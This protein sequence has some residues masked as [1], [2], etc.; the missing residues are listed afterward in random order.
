[1][2]EVESS[3]P[4]PRRGLARW[5]RSPAVAYFLLAILFLY[6]V[7]LTGRSYLLR[8]I[9]TFFH[10]WQVAVR[11][12]VQT[13]HLPLWNHDTF[14][15]IPLLANLQSGVFYPVNWLHWVLPFDFSLTLGM[16]IHLTLAGVLMYRFLGRVGVSGWNG[17]LGGALF[18]LS[19]WS[20]AYLEFPMKLGSAVWIP[21]L[22]TGL[23]DAMGSGRRRG[24]ATAALAVALSILAG[25]PQLAMFGLISAG[26]LWLFLVGPVWRSTDL[27]MGQKLH[28]I[29]ALPVAGIVAGLVAA[30][31]LVP[32]A[33]MSA[34]S[35]KAQPYEATVAM[36]RSLD[37]KGLAGLVDP[38]FLGFPGVDRYWGGEV[39]EYCFGAF[40]VGGVGFVL[41]LLAL[42]TLGR[43]SR[44]RRRP[45]EE[46][47]D[48]PVVPAVIPRF[49]FT[50]LVV[51]ILLALGKN[52]PLYPL[53]HE[54][55]PGFGRSRW[56][57][58]AGLLIAAALAPLAGIGLAYVRAE[59][60]RLRLASLA[61]VTFGA[62]MLVAA[63]VAGGPLA[64]AW[65]SAQLAGSPA[66][67]IAAYDAWHD[68]WH[69]S[70]W[71]R[72]GLLVAAGALGLL[73]RQIRSRV[74]IA[75]IAVVLLD[76]FLVGR[77]FEYPTGRDFYDTVPAANRAL[78][79]ELD[80]QRI[81][82][83][84]ATDQLGNF[85]YGNRNPTAFA[86][87]RRAMLCNANVPAGIAQANGCEPLNP[88]RHEAFS[89]VFDSER[90]PHEIRERIFDL[91][92]AARLVE[93]R[94]VRPLEIPNLEDPEAGLSFN[95]HRPRLGRA[96]VLTGWRTMAD[97]P[98]A[99]DALT[100]A[101]HSP[102]HVTLVEIPEDAPP[103]A[104][105]DRP[106]RGVS[107]PVEWSN[108]PNSIRAAWAAGDGG[109]LRIL[110]S[111]A[112]GWEAT[113]N[114][115]PAP[116]LRSDFLFL[117]VPVPP[118]SVEVELNYRP[119]SLRTGAI[120]SAVGLLL[121][122]LLC[123]PSRRVEPADS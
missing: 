95:P 17:F 109:I 82:T 51:G 111:W 101:N 20:L 72:A 63:L 31:Q 70:L 78:A 67:Q 8:D 103:L 99:L 97:G 58:T 69:A 60:E 16:V 107:T 30:I 84:R 40:Y 44:R 90:T 65:R 42:P 3:A 32:A 117:A 73:L 7:T 35:S 121:L 53:L 29:G 27:P 39:V 119:A 89:Q 76:L 18:A 1:M 55:I 9:L 93:L 80:G 108:G 38:F 48:R 56:P 94:G 50:L 85:L 10:P 24:V 88:R 11:D 61:L 59:H 54:F 43:W 12:L 21:L 2:S 106:A 83:A 34:L 23:W 68:E 14:C 19:S 41:A 36:S 96:S 47:A 13:G 120:A 62:A 25:Y 64:D 15:G 115:Q 105:P 87:A 37:W 118:G 46:R 26:L 112:P 4:P 66:Y 28:R 113:V 98:A 74:A 71:L 123:L 122:A 52:T 114:G 22:W 81:Y 100:A 6:D 77:A 79:A 86:W 91:W 33:E 92:D 49:L 45:A 75:W 5:F 57:A 104:Q 116:V 102:R 110:E